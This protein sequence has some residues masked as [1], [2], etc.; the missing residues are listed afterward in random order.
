MSQNIIDACSADNIPLYWSGGEKN[1]TDELLFRAKKPTLLNIDSLD[2]SS[3][4]LWFVAPAVMGYLSER[5]IH[6]NYFDFQTTTLDYQAQISTLENESLV[7]DISPAEE[8]QYDEE[9][10]EDILCDT[11]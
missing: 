4:F 3:H 5:S 1:V 8:A 6:E 11:D 9:C 2:Y 7:Q 10:N